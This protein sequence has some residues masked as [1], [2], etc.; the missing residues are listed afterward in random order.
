MPSENT[1]RTYTEDPP[2]G[3]S[4]GGSV[5]TGNVPI[6]MLPQGTN[7][8][9]Q[10]ASLSLTNPNHNLYVWTYPPP[11]TSQ[12]R[13]SYSH[14]YQTVQPAHLHAQIPGVKARMTAK[15]LRRV[16][17]HLDSQRAKAGERYAR[18]LSWTWREFIDG[19]GLPV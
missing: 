15:R 17:G 6:H 13:P 1:H 14:P 11:K 4:T 2:P 9:Q 18:R 3:P 16:E 5:E 12:Q 10:Y 7:T 19:L 8:L